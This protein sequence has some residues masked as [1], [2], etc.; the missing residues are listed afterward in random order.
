MKIKLHGKIRSMNASEPD[1]DGRVRIELSANGQV[2]SDKASGKEAHVDIVLFVKT[3][4]A[5]QIKFG[6]PMTIE[7]STEE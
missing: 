7:L 3:L 4:F 5:E 6:Q 2:F 1:T